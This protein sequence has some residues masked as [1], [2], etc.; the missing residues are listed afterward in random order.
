MNEL[1][2]RLRFAIACLQ[3]RPVA[4]HL[5]VIDG[6]IEQKPAQLTH[7]CI[8]KADGMW[9]YYYAEPVGD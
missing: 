5:A 2:T 3:G 6:M 8:S 7:D 1:F 9:R 4:R